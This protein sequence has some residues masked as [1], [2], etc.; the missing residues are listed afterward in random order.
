MEILEKVKSLLSHSVPDQNWM[1]VFVHLAKKHLQKVEGKETSTQGLITTQK[2]CDRRSEQ[3]HDRTVNTLKATKENSA[4]A[5][6]KQRSSKKKRKYISI[7]VIRALRK[8]A[9]DHCEFTS[10]LTGKR[11]ESKY[12]TQT[13]HKIPFAKGGDDSPKN[14]RLLCAH[15]N[16]HEARKM[17]LDRIRP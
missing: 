8:N 2:Q 7:K 12:Q 11:C 14:L 6:S 4:H 5:S 3:T 17:G 1:E 13:D 15:H 9:E 10:P 16:R